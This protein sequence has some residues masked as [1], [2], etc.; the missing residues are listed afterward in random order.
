[1]TISNFVTG[2][3]TSCISTLSST[4]RTDPADSTCFLC[5]YR[6]PPHGGQSPRRLK[7][8]LAPWSYCLFTVFGLGILILGGY[9]SGMG[10]ACQLKPRV[11]RQLFQYMMHMALDGVDGDVQFM[12]NFLVAVSLGDKTNHV[13][14]SLGHFNGIN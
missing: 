14:F 6:R 11:E 12:G 9:A 4:R 10:E 8:G 1:M 5:K 7:K 13:L 3:Q 2:D